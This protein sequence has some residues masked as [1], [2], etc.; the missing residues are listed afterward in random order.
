MRGKGAADH[1]QPVLK[2]QG[3]SCGCLLRH[4]Q[5]YLKD[6]HAL[7]HMAVSLLVDYELPHLSA[8]RDHLSEYGVL[9]GLVYAS[10]RAS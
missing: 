7:L 9:P 10:I 1:R 6:D 4:G 2:G 5:T 8:H 3:S